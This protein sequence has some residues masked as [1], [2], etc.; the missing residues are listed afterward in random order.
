MSGATGTEV[1]GGETIGSLDVMG[2]IRRA[3][4]MQAA[5]QGPAVATL[6]AAWVRVHSDDPLLYAVLFNQ[7]V[8]LTDLGDIPGAR[9]A[10]EQSLS[11]KPDFAPAR[12]NL[13]RV[14]ER[15]G[16]IDAA[17]ATWGAAID[18]MAGV[19]GAA[20]TSK[21]TAL[22]QMARVLEENDRDAA[23]ET[24]LRQALDL[25]RDLNEA[26]QHYL[27]LRQRQCAWPVIEPWER[28][29]HGKL[30]VGLSPLSAAAYTDDPWLHLGLAAAYAARDVAVDPDAI[31]TRHWA[32]TERPDG[33]SLRIG[34]L[35][36]D[37]RHHAV[38]YLMSEVMELHDKAKVETFAYYC[39]IPAANDSLQARYRVAADH[40]ID[41]AAMTPEAAARR[42]AD[43]GIQ[44]LVDVNGYTRE[45][46]TKLVALRPA[47]I[48][49]NWLGFP[50]TMASP[51][52]HYIVAD[53][54][55]I[56][57]ES[58]RYYSEKVVR[59][60]CYQ[61]T[62][63]KRAVAPPPESRAAIGLP[64]TGTVFCCFNGSHKITRFV[65]E[66]W[67]TILERV[68]GSVLW[69]LDGPA[70]YRERMGSEAARRGID[71]ARLVYA[72]KLRNPEHLARLALADL[73]LDTTPYGAHTT[74]S[75]ALW[76]GV[77]VLTVSGRSFASR[78]CG[79]LVRS[80]G[81]PDLV[82]DTAADYIDRAV[83]L[84]RDPARLAQLKQRLID[85]RDSSVL[86]D[87]PGLVAALE[88]LYAGMWRDLRAGNLPAPDLAN[89]DLLPGLAGDDHERVETQFI[90]DYD[91]LWRDRLRRRDR[92]RPIP[93]IGRLAALLGGSG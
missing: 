52:H 25:D 62:D 9:A 75:D 55:I 60:P 92:A 85:G 17:V 70:G 24:L 34:Y 57:P 36:S 13:G 93:R 4:A 87:V 84:G 45:G 12:I 6:Y 90:G 23:A 29:P 50:G 33:A 35:S 30:L 64:E 77:P 18:A 21:V 86:F 74:A 10:L 51:H 37:L 78:V 69:L 88:D 68:P 1:A 72:P 27:A 31:I 11:L 66:R 61:P 89:L 7:S 8:V 40:F 32:A 65:I 91:R 28:M 5:G 15:L 82:V 20:I 54:W 49:V 26:A 56:P 59:L 76:M 63:R 2:L 44:I 71:P 42:I 43:D 38:G 41:V 79:S 39:G 22:T 14:L 83:A 46:R 48:I 81:L 19:D 80:A 16:Q 53:P 67:L 58:E 3:E 73:V 47:P